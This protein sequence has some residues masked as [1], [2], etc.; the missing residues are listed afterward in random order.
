MAICIS[1]MIASGIQMVTLR[2]GNT[3]LESFA[4]MINGAA[5]IPIMSVSYAFSVEVTY[6]MPE[7]VTNGMLISASLVWGIIHVTYG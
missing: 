1:V 6:P 4:M 2:T 7:A 3:V 5:L